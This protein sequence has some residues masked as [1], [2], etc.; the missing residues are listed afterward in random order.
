MIL[1]VLFVLGSIFLVSLFWNLTTRSYGRF[2]WARK[3][4]AT[5]PIILWASLFLKS[6]GPSFWWHL[7]NWA[8]HPAFVWPVIALQCL[9]LF[10]GL[11]HIIKNLVAEA[12]LRTNSRRIVALENHPSISYKEI[13]EAAGQSRPPK[14]FA[15]RHPRMNQ[16]DSSPSVFGVTRPIILVPASWLSEEIVNGDPFFKDVQLTSISNK[17]WRGA[18]SHELGHI[19]EMDGLSYLLMKGATLFVW[20]DWIYNVPTE[21][22]IANL[23]AIIRFLFTLGAPLRLAIDRE[24]ARQE[25]LAD[26]PE[27]FVDA[28]AFAEVVRLRQSANV[29]DAFEKISNWPLWAGTS[30]ASIGTILSAGLIWAAPG[31]GPLI[32]VLF[33]NR[34]ILGVLP[35]YW[36]IRGD[37]SLIQEYGLIPPGANGAPPKIMLKVIDLGPDE[38]DSESWYSPGVNF[39]GALNPELLKEAARVEIETEVE[40]INLLGQ[41]ERLPNAAQRFSLIVPSPTASNPTLKTKVVFGGMPD[42]AENPLWPTTTNQGLSFR[43][44]SVRNL[45]ESTPAESI[46]CTFIAAFPGTYFIHP[47][48]I[49]VIGRN[50]KIHTVASD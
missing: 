28:E 8:L 39:G 47:P 12:V 23:D 25:A 46:S 1:V 9:I 45:E 4:F 10:F 44:L 35:L 41:R 3:W 29:Q 7:P 15:C 49:R 18:L 40:F 6:T 16:S 24:R 19:G 36:R 30:A 26:R 48:T 20:K 11:I 34:P 13:S 2:R 38:H 21:T 33:P 37:Q 50:G 32:R 17:A 27:T 42:L 22:G 5:F 31:R 14:I 43:Y